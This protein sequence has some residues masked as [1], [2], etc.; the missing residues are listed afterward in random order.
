MHASSCTQ[1]A[2]CALCS[3]FVNGA[4]AHSALLQAA[5]KLDSNIDTVQAS[6]TQE[7]PDYDRLSYLSVTHMCTTYNN[8]S[9]KPAMALYMMM[10]C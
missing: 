6:D 4:A 9:N 2:T 7:P 5:Y 10:Y 8:C 3:T 1:G